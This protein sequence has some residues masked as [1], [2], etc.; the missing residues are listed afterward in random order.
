MAVKE[1]LDKKLIDLN[2]KASTKDEV[3]RHLA[4]LLKDAGYL[5]DL[6]GY[7]ADVHLREREGIT[8]IGSHIAIPHGKSESV[9]NV[10]IAVGITEK[11]V[12]WESYDGQPVNLFFLFAV[13]ADSK[14][15]KDHLRLIA[16]LAGK[17]GN[18]ATMNQLQHARSYEELLDAFS[19]P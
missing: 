10:G 19:I 15:T 12:E 11:M 13:P 4:G 8:G 18:R 14:G 6:E 16:E 1:I 9:N 5:D 3:I 7:V 2:M 17:L